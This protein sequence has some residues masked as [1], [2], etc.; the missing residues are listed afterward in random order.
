[1][2]GILAFNARARPE[3]GLLATERKVALALGQRYVS[4][5]PRFPRWWPCSTSLGFGVVG[6]LIWP[7]YRPFAQHFTPDNWQPTRVRTELW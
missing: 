7:I 5:L 6:V 2:G 3:R 1:M 4:P